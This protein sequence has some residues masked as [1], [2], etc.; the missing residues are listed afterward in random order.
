MRMTTFTRRIREIVEAVRWRVEFAFVIG[1][2][3]LK[4]PLLRNV[5]FIAITG[6]AGKTTTKDLCAGILSSAGYQLSKTQNS[7]NEPTMVAK[8]V[9]AVRSDDRYAV[10]EISGGEPRAMDWP[11]KLFKPRIAVVTFIQREHARADFGLEDIASEKFRLVE[12][13]PKDG[14]A[15]LNFDDPLLRERG[16][17]CKRKVIWVGRGEGAT[18]RLL[19]CQS[20]WPE[21]LT[22]K[23]EYEGKTHIVSTKLHGEHLA[24]SVLCALAVALATGMEMQEAIDNLQH[25]EP[26]EGRMQVVTDSDGVTFLRDDW[27]APL[28]SLDAPMSFMQDATANRKVIVIGTLSDYSRSASKL[29]PQVAERALGIADHVIFVGPHAHRATKRATTEQRE[30]LQGFSE[31]RQASLHLNKILRPG[32][33]VMLKGTTRVD[34]L[35]RL[36][37]DR[38]APIACWQSNCGKPAL[39]TRC[40]KLYDFS[41]V[42]IIS[43][44]APTTADVAQPLVTCE[45]G[46]IALVGLGNPGEKYRLT[47]HNAGHIAIDAIARDNDM[48]WEQT[49][50]GH[51]AEGSLQGLQVMLIKADSMINRSGEALNRVLGAEALTR[52]AVVIHDDMDLESGAVKTRRGGG[53]GGHLGVRSII[54]VC[55]T[56]DF[57]RIRLGVRP[58]GDDRKSRQLVHQSFSD[59]ELQQLTDAFSSCLMQ[60][61]A[62][63]QQLGVPEPVTP[64]REAV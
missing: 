34:H 51:I 42:S 32:D 13:L 46:C 10:L 21:S 48:T 29:Y 61:L 39:C 43:H 23:I 2:T 63:P 27:K 28:W 50:W 4:K 52:S 33:L 5:E 38:E 53:D 55:Q 36:M 22:L 44:D 15:I 62:Q 9:A 7:F 60:L 8:T 25:Q 14:I 57:H 47:R 17:K 24:L 54:N 40:P 11:L 31:A 1:R 6:S 64:K 30:R 37:L 18:V 20:K 59:V 56:Q 45:K 12:A 26:S 58:L 19:E 41:G 49:P 35:A 16:E 3:L